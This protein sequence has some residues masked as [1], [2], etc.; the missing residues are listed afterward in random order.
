ML[1]RIKRYNDG[2]SFHNEFIP[3]NIIS[4]KLQREALV[5]MH[6]AN[7]TIF[8][9]KL[10]GKKSPVTQADKIHRFFSSSGLGIETVKTFIKLL[11]TTRGNSQ[12]NKN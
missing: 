5:S 12:R 8:R 11:T 4:K 9:T 2:S 1:A 3:S 6:L 10:A 7:K